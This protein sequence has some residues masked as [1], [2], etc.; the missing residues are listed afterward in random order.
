MSNNGQQVHIKLGQTIL[1][2][3]DDVIYDHWMIMVANPTILAIQSDAPLPPHTQALYKAIALGQTMLTA[4]GE[5]KC[6][7]ANPP[8]LIAPQDFQVQVIVE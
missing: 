1:M 7:K 5:L 3:L 8:C 6:A 2:A 4:K